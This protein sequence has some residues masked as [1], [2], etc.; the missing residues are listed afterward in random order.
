MTGRWIVRYIESQFS[1]SYLADHATTFDPPFLASPSYLFDSSTAFNVR[2]GKMLEPF[3]ES[4]ELKK[5]VYFKW[6][7]EI[8][9]ARGGVPPLDIA[10]P[11]SK[12]LSAAH[13]VE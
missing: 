9:F 5:W 12:D 11:R 4:G 10:A 2:A 13:R 1:E 3:F 7:W 8:T 6:L